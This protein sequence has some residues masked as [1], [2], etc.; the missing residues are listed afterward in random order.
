MKIV[1]TV[2]FSTFTTLKKVPYGIIIKINNYN[3]LHPQIPLYKFIHSCYIHDK[4]V[5]IKILVYSQ[6]SRTKRSSKDSHKSYPPAGY[7]NNS[8]IMSANI[9]QRLTTKRY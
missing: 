4:E 9:R 1:T 7:C 3:Q 2:C 6:C 8:S 5:Y